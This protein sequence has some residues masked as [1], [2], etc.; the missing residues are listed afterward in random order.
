MYVQRR[1]DLT[2]EVKWVAADSI[3]PV[4]DRP[5]KIFVEIHAR[6]NSFIAVRLARIP[7]H[8]VHRQALRGCWHPHETRVASAVNAH[9]SGP[10]IAC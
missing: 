6:L 7:V 5:R 4:P 10:V 9:T 2:N 8:V 3:V 1:L